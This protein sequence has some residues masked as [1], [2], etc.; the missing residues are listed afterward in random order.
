MLTKI[1]L[2]IALATSFAFGQLTVDSVAV[3]GFPNAPKDNKFWAQ[4]FYEGEITEGTTLS[5]YFFGFIFAQD[6]TSLQVVP[7]GNI[8]VNES[9]KR[10]RWQSEI[11]NL[12]LNERW[13]V[14]GYIQPLSEKAKFR[15]NDN[16]FQS[17]GKWWRPNMFN[18]PEIIS[19]LPNRVN[20]NVG[21][22]I[23]FSVSAYGEPL[24]YEWFRRTVNIDSTIQYVYDELGEIIDSSYTYQYTWNAPIKIDGVT[25]SEFTTQPLQP[26]YDRWKVFVRIYNNLGEEFS[27]QCLLRVF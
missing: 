1:F 11:V 23:T 24:F 20:G 19:D 21:G 17:G 8:T 15:V 6:R 12:P 16:L 25:T 18:E 4:C 3:E 26:Q 2:T 7:A 14:A 9:L 22:E 13:Y 10:I 5:D 27:R